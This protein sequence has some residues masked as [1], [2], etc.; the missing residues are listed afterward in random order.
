MN[1][2]YREQDRANQ[3]EIEELKLRKFLRILNLMF[4][5]RYPVGIECDIFDSDAFLPWLIFF[6]VGSLASLT[7]PIFT[8]H[9]NNNRYRCYNR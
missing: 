7:Y 8:S 1:N 5:G 4:C 2:V 6:D 9:S 3:L